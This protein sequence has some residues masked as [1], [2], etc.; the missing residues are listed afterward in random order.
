MNRSLANIVRSR[1]VCLSG[2]ASS[3]LFGILSADGRVLEQRWTPSG[4]NPPQQ[5]WSEDAVAAIIGITNGNSRLLN[6]LFT[7]MEGIL[8][9]NGLHEI[10]KAVVEAARETLVMGEA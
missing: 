9:I 2:I 1:A 4:V 7:Q 5:P 3:K 6:R 8:E 10:T